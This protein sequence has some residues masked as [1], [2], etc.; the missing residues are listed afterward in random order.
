MD[1]YFQIILNFDIAFLSEVTAETIWLA[2]SVG[3]KHPKHD[4]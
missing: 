1:E 4:N 2:S 3:N